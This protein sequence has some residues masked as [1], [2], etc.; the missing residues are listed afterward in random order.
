MTTQ[1]PAAPAPAPTAAPRRRGRGLGWPI[2][3]AAVLGT[4]VAVNFW[5]LRIA[6]ADPS[7]VVEPDYYRK[8]LHWDDEMAQ[9]RANVALGWRLAPTLAPVGPEHRAE[10]A[11]ALTDRAGAPLSGATVRVEAFPIV[12]SAD[13]VRATL[14]A[15]APA[16]AY[17]G[18]L[19]VATTGQWELRFTV[20]RGGDRFTAADRVTAARAPT[21]H[22][23]ASGLVAR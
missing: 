18:T 14:A 6:S 4:T 20:V 17:A 10:L 2:G 22:A 19:A 5:V 21:R 12:R 16:G 7:M 1:P 8:A 23:D 15:A 13:V 11:V 9:A 3:I